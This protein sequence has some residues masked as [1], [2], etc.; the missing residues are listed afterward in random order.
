MTAGWTWFIILITALNIAGSAWLLFAT[1]RMQPG[2]GETTG[3]VW[4][5]DLREY[6]H[7]L[8]RWWL[9][10]FVIT[11]IF[12]VGYLVAY[13]GLGSFTGSLGWTQH[14]QWEQEVAA[15]EAAAAPVYARFEGKAPEALAG[16]PEALQIAA[17]LFGNNCATCHGADARGA[18]GFPNLTDADWIHGGTPDAIQASIAN[19]RVGVMPPWGEMLGKDG[20]EQVVAYVQSLSGQS[21]DAAL[22]TAGKERFM[23]VC[24]ACHGADGRGQQALGAPNLTDGIWLYGGSADAIRTTIVKGRQNQ[25]PAQLGLLGETRVR[26]LAGYILSLSGAKGA[27]SDGQGT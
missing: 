15:A 11:V 17:R 16:D 23:Q 27:A 9:W 25:M 4:D 21:S 20:V 6:N 3:H 19:G 10:L 1:A 2:E 24:A 12:A 26:L 5:G 8:P 13:P 22:A 7:P 18:P 14:G